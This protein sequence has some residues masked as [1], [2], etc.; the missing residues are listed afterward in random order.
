MEG[1]VWAA[2][3]FFLAGLIYNIVVMTKATGTSDH[4]ADMSQAIV[5]V[6]IVDSVLVAVLAL[7]GYFYTE[8]NPTA[9]DPY[10]MIMIH[11]SL[12]FSIISLSVSTL[13]S[14]T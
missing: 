12:L 6:A 9:K 4:Q 11:L 8:Q 14:T 7:I 1:Y 5:Q 13:Y 3:L 2:I 10:V